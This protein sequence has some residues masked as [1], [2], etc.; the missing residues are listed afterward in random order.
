LT[1]QGAGLSKFI[2]KIKI[3]KSLKFNRQFDDI[4]GIQIKHNFKE[5]THT[6]ELIKK[7]YDYN[8]ENPLIDDP[9][10]KEEIKPVRKEPLY[11]IKNLNAKDRL[12]SSKGFFVKNFKM[13][14]TP[15]HIREASEEF[16]K[17]SSHHITRNRS[18]LFGRATSPLSEKFKTYSPNERARKKYIENVKNILED[19]KDIQ[20][21]YG[22]RQKYI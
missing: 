14:P 1:P 17:N 13:L 12:K 20:T 18:G 3:Q 8:M 16:E 2:N 6:N 11:K 9:S 7:D 15:A 4:E 10:N 5:G 22:Q 19:C 21:E